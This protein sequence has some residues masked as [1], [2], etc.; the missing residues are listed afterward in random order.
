VKLLYFSWVRNKVGIAE[1]EVPLPDG[2]QDL[3]GLVEWLK[4]RSAGFEDAL[5]D[6]SGVR[7]AVNQEMADLDHRISDQDEIAV[8]P[9]MTGGNRS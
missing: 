1:E 8:F 7:M 9:P 5:A 3:G 2:V 6:M 4:K